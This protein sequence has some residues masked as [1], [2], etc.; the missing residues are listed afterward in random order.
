MKDRSPLFLALRVSFIYLLI[1]GLWIIF[2]DRLLDY[3][4]RDHEFN[5]IMQTVKGWIFVLATGTL[6]FVERKFANE[7]MLKSE[8]KFRRYLDLSIE[9]VLLVSSEGRVVVWNSAMERITGISCADV[10]GRKIDSIGIPGLEF[11]VIASAG[12]DPGDSGT[13]FGITVDGAVRQVES[14]FFP[15]T[16]GK[17]CLTGGI[18]RDVTR[19]RNMEQSL[20]DSLLEKETLLKEIHHRVKNNL[21]MITSLLS[22]QERSIKDEESIEAFRESRNRIHSIALIHENL[23]R[24][25]NLSLIN[26]GDYVRHMSSALAGLYSKKG[27][28]VVIRQEISSGLMFRI[29]T[30]IPFG[31]LLNELLTN[32]MKYAMPEGNPEIKVSLASDGDSVTLTVRDN[33]KGIPPEADT[34]GGKSIGMNLISNLSRQLG[35]KPEFSNDGGAVFTLSFNIR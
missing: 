2:S 35:G 17:D 4:V 6:L 16:S 1:A 10:I 22:I 25:D 11:D 14:I 24:R 28:E 20:K 23:Y 12:E 9:G 30:A 13:M 5:L 18:F 8:M 33:G 26:I 32:A 15:V 29:D 34:T 21:Q 27:R 3:F 7:A 31:L 19:R